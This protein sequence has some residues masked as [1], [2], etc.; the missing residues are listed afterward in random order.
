MKRSLVALVLV[1]ACRSVF[2]AEGVATST[3]G[4][5]CDGIQPVDV[6]NFRE[7]AEA[8]ASINRDLCEALFE[9][10]GAGSRAELAATEAQWR[11]ALLNF[12]ETSRA[13]ALRIAKV[14]PVENFDRPFAHLR[15]RLDQGNIN[16][17]A[18]PGFSVD[19]GMD[20]SFMF[21]FNDRAESARIQMADNA[22]CQ[23]QFELTCGELLEEF[24]RAFLQ[25]K[26]AY[27]RVTADR[28]LDQIDELSEDWREFL[29]TARSQTLL[30]LGLTTRRESDH[31][32]QGYLVGPPGRQWFLL[33][34]NLVYE[35]LSGAP[36]GFE[37][38]PGI[39]LEIIGINYWRKSDSPLPW[40]FGVSLATS[41]VDRPETD[42][43]GFGL[44]F[45][46]DNRYSLGFS[47]YD[48]GEFGV[49]LTVDLLNAIN[50]KKKVFGDY[51]KRM[52][53]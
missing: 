7:L 33:H 43:V 2:A 19:R 21:H 4:I 23:S 28:T 20:G 16:S 13:Q 17:L 3:A 26:S 11:E 29:A 6:P 52:F 46:V 12:A 18:L 15:A 25:Y 51:K 47:H 48:G 5:Q 39:A 35:H 8:S 27:S 45:H 24:R 40:P 1:A 49:Y 14:V 30:D 42:D 41:F 31:F 32:K 36:D 9:P 22:A 50:D 53:D 10:L 34:P 44:M 37:T 38:K